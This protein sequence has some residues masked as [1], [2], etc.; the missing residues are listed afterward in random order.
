MIAEA[1]MWGALAAPLG[2]ALMA[3]ARPAGLRDGGFILFA[4]IGAGCAFLVLSA[5]AGGESSAHRAGAAAAAR[6][7]WRSRLNHWARWSRR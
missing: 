1:A 4:C 5:V 3:F 7:P 6:R 2:Q